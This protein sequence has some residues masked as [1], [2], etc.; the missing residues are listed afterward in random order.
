MSKTLVVVESPAKA[1]TISRFLG[2]STTALASMGHIRDL[3]QNV[4]GVA[5]NDNFK[6]QYELTT[7][8]KKTL[9]SLR[10]AAVDADQIYLATDPDREGEAIAWHIKELLKDKCKGKFHRISFH[11]ITE[12]A[13]KNSFQQPGEIVEDLVNAQQARRVLDRL[14][15]YQVSP[16]LWKK[17][18]KGTS[19]GRVQ[20]VALRLIVE[21]EREILAFVPEEYWNFEALFLAGE[22]EKSKLK[23]KLFKINDQK[24][25]IPDAD[26]AVKLEEALQAE[27][28]EHKVSK[29]TSTPRRQQAPPPF[30]TSTLQQAASSFLRF[31]TSQTMRVAQNL[32]EGI[33]TGE[34]AVGLITYMRTDSVQV[35]KEA[36]NAAA[37][38]IKEKYGKEYLPAKPNVYRSRKT[39]QEA[40]EAIRP[41]D[42]RKTPDSLKS[43]LNSQQLRLYTL[44]WNRFLASQ[45]TAARQ[46]D[47]SI[48]IE[49]AAGA[50]AGLNISNV[51]E[52]P[53]E[54]DQPGTVCTFR[55]SARETLF[56]GYLVLYNIKDVAEDDDSEEVD[57][58]LPKMIPGQS[59]ELL[60]LLKEQCFTNPPKRFSEAALVRTLEQNG[61]GRPSTFA[62][63]INTIIQRKYIKKEKHALHPTQLGFDVNDFLVD[64]MPGLF[65]VG[66]TAEMEAQLDRIEEGE[67]DWINMLHEFYAMFSGWLGDSVVNLEGLFT[68]EKSLSVLNELFPE[69]FVFD[70]VPGNTNKRYDDENFVNSLRRSLE[71]DK[72]L[73]ER[74]WL[75]LLNVVAKY[76]TKNDY[77]FAILSKI[78]LEKTVKELI[79]SKEKKMA[80]QSTKIQPELYEL[81]EKM[82]NIE[83]EEPVKRGRRVYDD[84]KFFTSLQNQLNKTSLLSD[85]QLNALEKMAAKYAAMIENYDALRETLGWN[86][87]DKEKKEAPVFSEED[88]KKVD[89][90]I[91]M[92]LQI[93]NWREPTGRG[94]RTFNDKEFAA[95]LQEQYEQKGSL[96]ERQVAALHKMLGKYSEE[97][98]GFKENAEKLFGKSLLPKKLNEKCPQCSAPLL[99]RIGRSGP[100]IGCSAFPKCRYIAAKNKKQ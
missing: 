44:I 13:I 29:V 77:M 69:N 98:P 95:S 84:K 60:E 89:F 86:A 22:E 63:I 62:A 76:A 75:A 97:L 93:K 91:D 82:Q 59:C 4:L 92:C 27:S 66:F 12:S 49:S 67:L 7:N 55:V 54:N 64:R 25:R 43:V 38:F 18:G 85:A 36:Q 46:M 19:A 15:G 56:P 61:V 90:L 48:E 73:S 26:T 71:A 40:H 21:R 14:V 41:T 32:Y 81:M 99:E 87:E 52:K 24:F 6:P 96:S 33:E 100:F 53:E 42:I 11:E 10:S 30:I 72:D 8:G 74:Q 16:L 78:D 1:R 9:Q 28:V 68:V 39:A 34:G 80:E 37:D 47:H 79:S 51:F 94:K 65:N 88:K 58:I 31:S 57:G 20:S 83:W 70:K 23:T 2:D 50:L 35:A 5:V 17:I 45:M 3:P